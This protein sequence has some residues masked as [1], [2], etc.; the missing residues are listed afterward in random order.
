MKNKLKELRQKN[1]RTQQELSDFLKISQSNYSKYEIGSIEPDIKTLLNLSKYYNVSID[2]LLGN[3]QEIVTTN[4]TITPEQAKAVWFTTLTQEDQE[5]IN[6]Y[7]MLSYSDKLRVN[8]YI[9]SRL[10]S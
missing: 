2:Y 5:T 1:K 8:G 10:N 3:T 6:Y 4:T 7:L 9:L